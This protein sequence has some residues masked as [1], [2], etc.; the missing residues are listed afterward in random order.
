MSGT[1]TV[2]HAVLRHHV[3]GLFAANGCDQA[4][5]DTVSGVLV[6]GDLLGHHTHG[7][8]LATGYLEDLAAGR[9]FGDAGRLTQVRDAGAVAL[10]DCGHVLGPYAVETALRWAG[11]AARS[12]GVGLAVLAKSH[13]IGCLAAYLEAVTSQGLIAMI[14]SSDPT[15]ATVAPH[16]GRTAVYSPN[17]MAVGIPAP[18]PI[19]V[20]IST[21]TVTNSALA[22]AH[23]TNTSLQHAAIIDA[24]GRPTRAPS[25]FFADP[26]GA[27]LPL[28]GI[29]F[30][31]K[32]FGLGLMVEALTS[33]LAG[34]GR[35]QARGYKAASVFILLVD[36]DHLGGSEDLTAEM[37][38]LID[39]C[40]ESK[41]M[42]P[43][44]PVR[45]PGHRGLQLKK[46]HLDSGI[47]LPNNVVEQIALDTTALTHR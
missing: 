28:G 31:H 22:Q 45:L 39:S 26:P 5:A 3:A 14:M 8:A 16:G 33:G 18:V 23:A 20:D 42:R 27:I 17:P 12:H 44:Q 36:P 10:Y 11:R 4:V 2:D 47:P 46:H 37:Q 6:E 21:S 34:Y 24:A 41:P 7:V 43:D 32:G 40:T 19:L 35:K 38:H 29:E 1:T 25:D 30:G 15:V 13:H 9:A